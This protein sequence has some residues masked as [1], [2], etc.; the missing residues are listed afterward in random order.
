MEEVKE[1]KPYKNLARMRDKKEENI[2]RLNTNNYAQNA[3]ITNLDNDLRIS[4]D[5]CNCPFK[6]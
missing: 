5:V 3:F 6:S 2:L 1:E 4:L